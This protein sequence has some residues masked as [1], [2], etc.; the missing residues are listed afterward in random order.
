MA[1]FPSTAKTFPTLVDLADSVLAIHQNERG[2]EINAIETWL[3]ARKEWLSNDF[4]LNGLRLSWNSSTSIS[5]GAGGCFA[6]N[7]DFINVSAAI[8]NAS[9]SLSSS[10]WYHV[11]VYLSGGVAATEVVTTAP[12]AWK[13][14]AYSKTGDT[15][16]RYVGSI[17]TDGSGNVIRFIHN[18][19]TNNVM[20]VTNLTISPFR[21]L[22]GGTSTSTQAVNLAGALPVTAISASLLI[23]NSGT[24]FAQLVTSAGELMIG[25]ET[26]S[27]GLQSRLLPSGYPLSGTNIYY[28][29]TSGGILTIDVLGYDF[30]R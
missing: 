17:L 4:I 20:W 27:S 22:N 18:A 25:V 1:N 2:D 15:S 19:F 8:T 30:E 28:Y 11:Y 21:V 13:G 10:T 24:A 3:L 7:G 14:T 6:E 29:V 12:V 16:R 9:L 26:P 5:V 23:F